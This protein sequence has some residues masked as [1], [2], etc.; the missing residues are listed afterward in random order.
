MLAALAGR[1]V[2][3]ALLALPFA[4]LER[5]YTA[6]PGQRALGS[7]TRTNVLYWLLAAPLADAVGQVVVVVTVVALAIARGV[8]VDK[9]HI[10]A[11]SSADSAVLH[12]PAWLRV[13][14]MLVVTD[15]L[16]Y[17]VH[18]AFH[19]SARL[20]R[21]HALHHSSQQL[22]WFSAVRNHPLAEILPRPLVVVPVLLVGFDP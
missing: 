16:G 12:L 22:H 17:V 10:E 1:A 9:A 7:E 2:V 21:L 6:V 8:P 3:L 11:R 4:W 14:A 19:R 5:R 13:L 15:L 18:R 20:W